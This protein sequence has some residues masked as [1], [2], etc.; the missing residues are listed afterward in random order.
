MCIFNTIYQ[1][2]TYIYSLYTFYTDLYYVLY[3][4]VF[5]WLCFFNVN[6]S[7]SEFTMSCFVVVLLN[8][9]PVF[10]LWSECVGVDM[11]HIK[12]CIYC[13]LRKIALIIRSGRTRLFLKGLNSFWLWMSL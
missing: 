1:F 8:A 7:S 5:F 6:L 3:G 10:P 13:W 4:G 11:V 2:Y 12:H 9:W